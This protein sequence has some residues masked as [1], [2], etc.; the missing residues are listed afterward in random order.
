MKLGLIFKNKTTDE[1]MKIHFILISGFLVVA[2]VAMI[3][4]IV[5]P[6]LISNMS[7]MPGM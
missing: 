3:F 5:N 6:E 2:H 4:G 7:N 1:K